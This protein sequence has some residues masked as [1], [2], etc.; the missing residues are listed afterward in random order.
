MDVSALEGIGL[1][2][3]EIKVYLALLELGATKTGLLIEKS[4]LQSSVVYSALARLMEKGLVSS[5]KEGKM[6]T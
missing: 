3:A 1:T 5:I 6:S 2:N 4:G